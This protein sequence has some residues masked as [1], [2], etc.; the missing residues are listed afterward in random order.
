MTTHLQSHLANCQSYHTSLT[1]IPLISLRWSRQSLLVDSLR[2]V[3]LEHVVGEVHV[4]LTSQF[5]LQQGNLGLDPHDPSR[6]R[7]HTHVSWLEALFS[8]FLFGGV[9]LA[10]M[11]LVITGTDTCGHS[12]S[13]DVV[14]E[15][16][17]ANPSGRTGL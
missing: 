12:L 17:F 10:G 9:A 6:V 3:D 2:F 14:L 7:I 1:P 16:F 15:I 5:P 11:L 8:R 13:G 4:S